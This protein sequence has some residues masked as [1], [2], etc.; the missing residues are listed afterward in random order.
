V[1]FNANDH[2]GGCTGNDFTWE[3]S[4]D[5]LQE[6]SLFVLAFF[7]KVID[8]SENLFGCTLAKTLEEPIDRR[9]EKLEILFF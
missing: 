3:V 7:V 6:N 5:G 9:F 2:G 1:F 4:D 8:L